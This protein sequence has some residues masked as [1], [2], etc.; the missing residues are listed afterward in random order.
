MSKNRVHP[1]FTKENG[2]KQRLKGIFLIYDD[3]G[4]EMMELRY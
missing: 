3:V 1:V 2:D 4:T